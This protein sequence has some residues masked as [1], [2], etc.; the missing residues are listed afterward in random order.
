MREHPFECI[1]YLRNKK[2]KFLKNKNHKITR[3]QQFNQ[4]FFFIDGTIYITK[5][6]Y[7]KKNKKFVT[8]NKTFIFH[9]KNNWPIDID[10]PDDILVAKNFIK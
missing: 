10:H 6:K 9:L 1:E 7:L 8:E 5:I 3:R 2:W 4:D